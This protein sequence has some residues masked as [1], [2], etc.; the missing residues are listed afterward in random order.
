MDRRTAT[1]EPT[2]RRIGVL[3]PATIANLSCGFDVLGLALEGVGDTIRVEYTE[4]PGVR[5]RKIRGM[6][7]PLEADK[8]VAG[9]AVMALLESLENPCGIEMEID[10]GIAPGSG[11]GRSTSFLAAPSP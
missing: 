4:K 1:Y 7:L 9:V 5:I 11:I 3:A 6:D 2:R 10:K 8:N